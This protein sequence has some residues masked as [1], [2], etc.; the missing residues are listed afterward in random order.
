ME[1]H[2]V[3][4]R[5]GVRLVLR[6][7]TLLVVAVLA[8]M[9]TSARAVESPRFALLIGNNDYSSGV[10]AN[11]TN[12]TNDIE[13]VKKALLNDG[14]AEADIELIRNATRI[15]ILKSFDEFARRIGRGGAGAISFFYYSGHGAADDNKDNYLIP[16][17]APDVLN[18]DFWYHTVRLRDLVEL[19]NRAAPNAKHFVIFDA[20]RNTLTLKD[21]EHKAFLHQLKG[22][23]PVAVPGGMLIAFATAQ[24]QVASDVGEG[25]GPYARALAEE[26][27]K[28]DVEAITVFRNVQLRL[29]DSTGQQPWTMWGPLTEVYFAGRETNA[30]PTPLPQPVSVSVPPG[31]C[32]KNGKLRVVILAVEGRNPKPLADGLS[33][34]CFNIQTGAFPY[35]VHVDPSNNGTTYIIPSNKLSKNVSNDVEGSI[36][37]IA[38]LS[39]PPDLARMHPQ[40]DNLAPGIFRGGPGPIFGDVTIYLF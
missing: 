25:A 13:L 38:T 23:E 37:N 18:S 34:A 4:T 39:L 20:C 21:P 3:Q 22:F 16:V 27:V 29:L 12:P 40:D 6:V 32:L 1:E 2:P 19:L 10:G 33:S 5:F 35:K 28:P 17:D 31:E 36:I 7:G 9:I 24:G 30:I 8:Q 11:L 15:D 14:F 26:I